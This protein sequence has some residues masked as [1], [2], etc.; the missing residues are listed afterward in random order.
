M[1]LCLPNGLLAASGKANGAAAAVAAEK[2]EEEEAP[3]KAAP[4]LKALTT[5]DKNEGAAELAAATT[6]AAADPNATIALDTAAAPE[7]AAGLLAS[8][9]MAM[10]CCRI[11]LR[12]SALP[13]TPGT[14]MMYLHWFEYPTRPK[15]KPYTYSFNSSSLQPMTFGPSMSL[16][17]HAA[18]YCWHPSAFATSAATSALV[19]S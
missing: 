14:S 2:E 10:R 18:W 4:G 16:L 7:V 19:M 6:G 12:C 1:K 15:H 13:A 11:R 3:L 8:S 9:F 5:P 17:A